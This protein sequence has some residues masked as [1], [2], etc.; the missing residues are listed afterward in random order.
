M[1]LGV[2]V[3]P[4]EDITTKGVLNGTYLNSN[5]DPVPRLRRLSNDILYVVS[6]GVP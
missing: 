3:V 2:P 6:E 1:P 4:D 5:F